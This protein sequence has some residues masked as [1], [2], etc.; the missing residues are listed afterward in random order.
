VIL[1]LAAGFAL[2]TGSVIVVDGGAGGL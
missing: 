1:D 2:A